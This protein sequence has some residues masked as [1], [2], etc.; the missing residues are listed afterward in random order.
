MS[1]KCLTGYCDQ[2]MSAVMRCQQF[3][4]NDKSSYTTGPILTKLHTNDPYL[5]DPLLKK[6]KEN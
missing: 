6:P 5:G 4:L 2:S 3:P 1:T